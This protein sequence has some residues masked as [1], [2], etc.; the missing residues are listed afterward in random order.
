MKDLFGNQ[1][2]IEIET[3]EWWF[4]GRIIHKQNDFRIPKCVFLI[5]PSTNFRHFVFSGHNEGI[6]A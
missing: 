3:D 1:K 5:L 6:Y 2:P 4:N